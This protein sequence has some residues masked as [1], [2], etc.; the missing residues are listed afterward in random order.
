MKKRVE[1]KSN[2]SASE[3]IS[4]KKKNVFSKGTS[5]GQISRGREG[6]GG[7]RGGRSPV[8]DPIKQPTNNATPHNEYGEEDIPSPSSISNDDNTEYEE[9][10]AKMITSM[11]VTI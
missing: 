4:G 9:S 11:M 6:T 10:L 3:E 8:H 2:D 1:K 7:R 5:R